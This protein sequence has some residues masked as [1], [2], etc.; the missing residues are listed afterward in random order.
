MRQD[1]TAF[2]RILSLSTGVG[3]DIVQVGETHGKE[4]DIPMDLVALKEPF[5]EF[6]V[7]K[8]R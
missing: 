2:Q 8:L 1:T 4:K 6:F 3:L 5:L 7:V